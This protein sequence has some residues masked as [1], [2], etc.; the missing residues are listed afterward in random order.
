MSITG[1]RSQQVG[2]SAGVGVFYGLFEGGGPETA[3]VESRGSMM[4]L[5]RPRCVRPGLVR[6]L[7]SDQ[8]KAG[9]ETRRTADRVAVSAAVDADRSRAARSSDWHG[10]S[11]PNGVDGRSH[12]ADSGETLQ[13]I[14]ACRP[15]TGCRSS[16]ASLVRNLF[17]RLNVSASLRTCQR[18]CQITVR[19]GRE[20]REYR[21]NLR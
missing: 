14:L 8:E 4:R 21:L 15:S 6:S 16:H 7:G 12:E 20:R 3:D 5:A 13:Q 18:R 17:R 1:V 19:M 9:S 11:Q 2:Q 10:P